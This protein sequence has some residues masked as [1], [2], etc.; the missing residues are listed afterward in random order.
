MKPDPTDHPV[1]AEAKRETL[2]QM[3]VPKSAKTKKPNPF[4]SNRRR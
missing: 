2:R 1:V 3:S 4:I